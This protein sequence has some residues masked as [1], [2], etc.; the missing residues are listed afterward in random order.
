MYELNAVTLF[1]YPYYTLALLEVTD[2]WCHSHRFP[3]LRY[4]L[5]CDITAVLRLG[6]Y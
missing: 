4:S 5:L 6:V 3:W 2:R 1:I